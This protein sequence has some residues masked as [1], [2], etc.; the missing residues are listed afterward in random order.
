MKYEPHIAVLFHTSYFILLT[1]DGMAHGPTLPAGI[2]PVPSALRR[3][4]TRFGMVR[5]GPTALRARHLAQGQSTVAPLSSLAL[6]PR[7]TPP[8]PAGKPS[9]MRTRRLH[10]SPRLQLG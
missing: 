9:P 1:L 7:P 8:L 2:P 10:A 5:G 6:R 3:F 4:T